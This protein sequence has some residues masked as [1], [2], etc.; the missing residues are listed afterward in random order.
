MRRERKKEMNIS[1]QKLDI[2]IR[3]DKM[4]NMSAIMLIMKYVKFKID[5]L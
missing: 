1:Y 5:I 3:Y 2:R 4:R